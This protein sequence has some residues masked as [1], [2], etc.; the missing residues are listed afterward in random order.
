MQ[1]K[2]EDNFI[3]LKSPQILKENSYQSDSDH[4]SEKSKD[5]EVSKGKIID[6]NDDII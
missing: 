6:D 5:E 3:E 2:G 1:E 4:R